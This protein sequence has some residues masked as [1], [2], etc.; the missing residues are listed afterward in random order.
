M[1][2]RQ[3]KDILERHLKTSQSQER[4][5]ILR[6]SACCKK[7]YYGFLADESPLLFFTH[8]QPKFTAKERKPR[9]KLKSY[10]MPQSV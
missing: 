6:G 1:K 3:E 10:F 7:Y 4:G 8:F 9:W 5:K 2:I